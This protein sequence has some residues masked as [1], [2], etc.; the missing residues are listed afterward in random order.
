MPRKPKKKEITTRH[1]KITS[2]KLL[3]G[4][5]DILPGEQNYWYYIEKIIKK[6]ALT[7]D[8]E[9]ITTPILEETSLFT[10]TL[11]FSTD[12]IEKEMFSFIDK[13]GNKVTLRPEATSS[14]ARAYIEHGM[15]NL[16]QPVKL[17][18]LGP[19]FRYERPQ[20]GRLRQHHQTG[21]EVLGSAEPVV[22]AQLILL[23][24]NLFQELK[25]DITIQ[26]NTLG[27]L[28]CRKKYKKILVHYFRSKKKLL[29]SDCQKRLSKN[30]LRL[31]DCKKEQCQQIIQGAPQLVDHICDDCKNHFVKVLEYL[32]EA[33]IPYV[34]NPYLVRGL[35]YYNKTVFEIWS[36]FNPANQGKEIRRNKPSE[37]ESIDIS[38]LTESGSQMALGGGGRYDNLI[39]ILGG[40]PTPAC[41]AGFGIERIIMDLKKRE[42]TVPEK[43]KFDVFLAQL[44][45]T[46][47]KKALKLFEDLRKVN[48]KTAENFSKGGLR[49]QLEIAN[50]LGVKFTLII[51]QKEALDGT[52]LLR[53]MES[54][55]QEIINFSKIITEI[56]KRLKE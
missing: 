19:M 37:K 35:D 31:L 46:A 54:G 23:S 18:Y 47:K 11:G 14:I 56:K 9:K 4:M 51:G 6:I 44:G 22:D 2:P 48:I 34:L 36:A 27:C 20:E 7:Y 29:C 39:E 26:I 43:I 41:G 15:V 55:V 53:D 33:D 8:F 13:G 25:I 24:Y 28:E 10:R 32:D 16:P 5:K 42:V 38:T 40:Q 30:P 1:R 17:F 52:I 21:F 12:I 45:E 50:K 49:S 3:R